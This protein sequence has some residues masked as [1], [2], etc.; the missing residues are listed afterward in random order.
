MATGDKIS[1]GSDIVC[2]INVKNSDGTAKDLAGLAVGVFLIQGENR[3]MERYATAS[4][5]GFKSTGLTIIDATAGQLQLKIDKT[6]TAK[7]KQGPLQ[8][9]VL[10][11]DIDADFSQG[12]LQ[13]E[14]DYLLIC[15]MILGQNKRIRITP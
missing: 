13:Q 14:S 12:V 8:A 1:I 7:M 10:V 3:V 5:S 2:V 4:A 11:E 9:R 15:E 6:N